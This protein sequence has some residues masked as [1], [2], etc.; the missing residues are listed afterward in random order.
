MLLR[1]LVAGGIGS[2]SG[3]KGTMAVLVEKVIGREGGLVWHQS[4][5]RGEPSAREGLFYWSG[6]SSTTPGAA[7]LLP[8][9]FMSRNQSVM[10]H[11]YGA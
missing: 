3:G 9:S 6:V 1:S 2:H 10:R 5:A 7:A 4:R 8:G 11:T